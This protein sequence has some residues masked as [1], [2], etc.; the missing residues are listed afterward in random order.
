MKHEGQN[1]CDES[2]LEVK[3]ESI[4]WRTRIGMIRTWMWTWWL[5][6]TW[7][8]YYCQLLAGLLA[9]RVKLGCCQPYPY[10]MV[11]CEIKLFWNYFSLRRH[12]SE[13]ILSQHVETCVKLFQ[14]LIAL[15]EYF[16]TC[17]MSPK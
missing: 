9:I 14:K 1:L 17:S 4:F 3:P 13:I 12:P 15:H 7:I 2:G 16:P 10:A 6:R 5:S 11:T 8:S